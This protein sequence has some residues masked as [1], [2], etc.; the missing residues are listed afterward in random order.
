[1]DKELLK[2]AEEYLEEQREQIKA[3]LIRLVKIPSIESEAEEGAPFGRKCREALDEAIAL[4]KE[5]GF[6]AEDKCGGKYGLASLKKGGEKTICLY[7]HTDVVPV[8]DGWVYTEPFEPI[9]INGTLIGRGVEDNKS[10]VIASLYIGKMI[11]GLGLE[12][13]NNLNVFLGSSEETGM[14]DIMAFKENEKM[15]DLSI[16]PDNC[17]PVCVGEK[18][19]CHFWAKSE[20]T[21]SDIISV[22]GGS[23]FNVVLDKATAKIRYSEDTF[24]ELEKIVSKNKRLELSLENGELVL[25]ALGIAKH[26][27][28]PEGSLNA[29]YILSEAISSL[30]TINES[31]REIF[32]AARDLLKTPYG[33]IYGIDIVDPDFGPLTIA[34]GMIKTENAKL[35]I[36]FDMRYG[37]VASGEELIGKIEKTLSSLS[38]KAEDIKNEAGY[39]TANDN[40]IAL[41]FKSIYEEISGEEGTQNQ[42]SS[43]GTYARYLSNA[44]SVGTTVP[45]MVAPVDMPEG[46]G[47]CHQCDEC[48]F[49]DSFLEAIKIIF[50]MVVE[51]DKIL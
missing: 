16:V 45:Y 36:S 51:A 14:A 9:E 26:A 1:M 13:K 20:R 44:Y 28:H 17:F 18:G 33:E 15:P 4:Y 43:G 32:T 47:E 39:N 50:M 22:V 41:K 8:S 3:D 35:Y 10:G 48:L 30:K 19:I 38:F 27:A 25:T 49:I 40:P 31:D 29:A 11:K 21:L 23:A 5:N 12:F 46:H 2:K 34:N 42:R 7:G 6:E 24:E 37:S